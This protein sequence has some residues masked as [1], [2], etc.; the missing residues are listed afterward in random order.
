ME[1]SQ[2]GRYN[3]QSGVWAKLFQIKASSTNYT[4]TD[5]GITTCTGYVCRYVENTFTTTSTNSFS[6]SVFGSGT[7]GDDVI[8]TITLNGATCSSN[9]MPQTGGTAGMA[10]TACIRWLPPG[11]YTV[12]LLVYGSTGIATSGNGTFLG[13][14]VTF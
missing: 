7:Y 14:I 13:G 6:A 2:C 1:Q 8:T 4:T 5:F 10:S 12:R 11:T 3:C 9:R